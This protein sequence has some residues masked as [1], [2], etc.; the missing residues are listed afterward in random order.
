MELASP[1]PPKTT[2]QNISEMFSEGILGIFFCKKCRGVYSGLSPP[3]RGGKRNEKI[4]N[5]EEKS[6][7]KRRET[8]MREE[9]KR[10]KGGNKKL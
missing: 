9:E 10:K 1:K 4:R 2:T 7:G 6:K 5:R 3:L 8:K